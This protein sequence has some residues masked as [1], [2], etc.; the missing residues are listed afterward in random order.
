M[1]KMREE[2][3]SLLGAVAEM[4]D[5]AGRLLRGASQAF[6]ACDGTALGAI[7]EGERAINRMEMANDARCLRVLALYQPEADDLRSVLMALKINNDLERIG[8]HA[9]NVAE[10]AG[11]AGAFPSAALKERFEH[12]AEV[13]LA[14]L[15]DAVTA[16]VARDS[17]LAKAVIE[18]DDEVDGLLRTIIAD[19]L[20]A[21]WNERADRQSAIALVF[22]AKDF[23]RVADLCTNLAEDVVFM[24]EG[25]TLKHQGKL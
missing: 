2:I 3:Q 5:E 10:R 13:C 1:A 11:Q 20:E 9:L 21:G 14:M 25:T 6:L 19:V 23:E 22:A 12:M 18:R 15:R 16:F 4:A 8:D 7:R 17:A 24:A